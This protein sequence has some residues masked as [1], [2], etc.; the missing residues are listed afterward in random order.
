MPVKILG[1]Q[2]ERFAVDV[3]HDTRIE[4]TTAFVI[5]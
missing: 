2:R 3:V 1:L 5:E 4:R